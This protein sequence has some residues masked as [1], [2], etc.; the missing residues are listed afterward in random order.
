MANAKPSPVSTTTLKLPAKLKSRVARLAKRSQRTPHGLMLEAIEREVDRQ[1][2][3][4]AFVREALEADRAIDRGAET[5]AAAD[6]H[7][8]IERLAGTPQASRPKPWRA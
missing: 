7:A 2:R 4:G 8:W 5:F 6:V 3:V 1:E